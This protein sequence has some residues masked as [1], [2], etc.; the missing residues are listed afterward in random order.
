[1]KVEYP[2]M[3]ILFLSAETSYQLMRP[4]Q[5]TSIQGLRHN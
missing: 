2:N 1:M 4:A 5:I 3:E